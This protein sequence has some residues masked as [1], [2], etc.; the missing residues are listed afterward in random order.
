MTP[1]GTP[2]LPGSFGPASE[3]LLPHCPLAMRER[4]Q[5]IAP[6]NLGGDAIQF[7]PRGQ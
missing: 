5:P 1:K 4:L 6:V 2:F 3:L 7:P